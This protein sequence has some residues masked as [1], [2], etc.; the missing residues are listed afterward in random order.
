MIQAYKK[1]L[2]MESV[3]ELK[4][5]KDRQALEKARNILYQQKYFIIDK[6]ISYLKQELNIQYFSYKII[7]LDGNIADILVKED[8]TI[9]EE[10]ING[11]EFVQFNVEELIDSRMFDNEDEIIIVDLNFDENLLN[12]GYMCDSLDYH[13]L[14][15]SDE[16]KN[17]LSTFINYVINR[18]L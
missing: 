16:I 18:N 17:T 8:S 12:L 14:S 7:D 5:E 1:V 13:Y 15:Y 3:A 4:L 10:A 2:E 11:K 6:L 9:F